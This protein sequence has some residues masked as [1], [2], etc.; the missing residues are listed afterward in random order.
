MLLRK[1]QAGLAPSVTVTSQPALGRHAVSS[2]TRGSAGLAMTTSRIVAVLV[3]YSGFQACR[4]PQEAHVVSDF[5]TCTST[6]AAEA[7]L[8]SLWY[9][10]P[11]FHIASMVTASLR[12]TA[13]R[14]L[15]FP[16]RSARPVPQICT[17]L[18]AYRRC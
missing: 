3:S 4:S 1:L 7:S 17:S 15:C 5:S 12:A 13:V 18:F 6:V 9:G 2:L 11:D 8:R 14:A 10:S 16:I